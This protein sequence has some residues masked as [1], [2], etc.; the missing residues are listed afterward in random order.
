MR[1]EGSGQE[2]E[3]IGAPGLWPQTPLASP[4]PSC[5]LTTHYS[6]DYA[7]VALGVGGRRDGHD[8]EGNA[9]ADQVEPGLAQALTLENTHHEEV[10]LQAL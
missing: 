4:Q 7:A 6:L 5:G 3:G 9:V 2:P 1:R 10:E 8:E